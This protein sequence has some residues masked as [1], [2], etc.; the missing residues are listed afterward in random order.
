MDKNVDSNVKFE[1]FF[2]IHDTYFISFV[3]YR[4]FKNRKLKGN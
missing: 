4:Y 2:P 1:T 3:D